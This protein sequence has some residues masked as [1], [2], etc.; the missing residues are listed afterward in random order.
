MKSLSTKLTGLSKALATEESFRTAFEY[1]LQAAETDIIKSLTQ[2]AKYFVIDHKKFEFQS[3][4]AIFYLDQATP[5]K[6]IEN[7]RSLCAVCDMQFKN[8]KQVFYW[9]FKFLRCLL[10]LVNSAGIPSAKHVF[11]RLDLSQR[12]QNKEAPFAKHVIASSMYV[13]CSAVRS[14]RFQLTRP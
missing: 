6:N 14:K 13:I 2:E 9:Y 4:E 7:G 12:P 1:G 11:P 10:L 3:N 8:L 5:S